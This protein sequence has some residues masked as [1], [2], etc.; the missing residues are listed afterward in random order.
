MGKKIDLTGQRFGM[1]TVLGEA[2]K[3]KHRNVLW[4]C[5][6]DCGEE[7]KVVGA[8]LRAGG[9]TSCGC[10]GVKDITGQRFGKLVALSEIE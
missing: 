3:N 2:G 7:R 9:S 6:C 4:N 8:C 5:H 10:V 1:W